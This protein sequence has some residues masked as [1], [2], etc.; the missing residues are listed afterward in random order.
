VEKKKE[1]RVVL[2]YASEWETAEA[3]SDVFR[4]WQRVM[5]GKWK[6]YEVK[7]ESAT[8]VEGT[9][10]DGPFELRLDLTRVTSVE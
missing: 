1:Q 9:G 4:L 2:L 6:K 7:T 10:D 8:R 5:K 3:A